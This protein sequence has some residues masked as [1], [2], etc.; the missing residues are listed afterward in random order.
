MNLNVM[1]QRDLGEIM[2]GWFS[3]PQNPIV[4]GMAGIIRVGGMGV[5][6]GRGGQPT[7]PSP[8]NHGKYIITPFTQ[9]PYGMGRLGQ[10][11]IC[12]SVEQL[13]GIVDPTDP[14]QQQTAGQC[15]AG[16]TANFTQGGS[17]GTWVCTANATPATAVTTATNPSAASGVATTI[18]GIN[19]NYLIL[20]A[21]VLVAFMMMK[22]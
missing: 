21:V 9:T 14:C 15:P 10:A 7:P 19:T 16:T 3:V 2:P 4:P 5:V 8:V 6:R 17:G 22:K 13:Q 20:G 11:A 1:S 12:P 18:A